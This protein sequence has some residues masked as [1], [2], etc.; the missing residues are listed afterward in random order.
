MNGARARAA[1]RVRLILII[2]TLIALALGSFWVQEVMRR[3]INDSLPDKARV[4]PDYYVE[5]FRFVKM[6]IAG[7]PR[8]DIAGTRLLHF[9]QSDTYEIQKPVLHSRSNPESPMTMRAE[10]AIVDD[11]HG[12]IHMHDKVQL[13]RPQTPE[14]ER[15][16]MNS[17]YLLILPD[18]DLLQTDRPV[19]ISLGLSTMNGVGMSVNNATREF[20][21]LNQAH[22]NYVSVQAEPALAPAASPPTK[23]PV[24]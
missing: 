9:P 2:G 7:A 13:D 23:M 5:Q 16:Q 12:K 10:K 3:G 24:R 22:A 1:L 15:F 11:S 20:R 18:D 8:Y 4:E 17:E 6:S 14:A 21:L 19:E